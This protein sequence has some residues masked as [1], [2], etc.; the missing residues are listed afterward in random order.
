MAT[1]IRPDGGRLDRAPGGGELVYLDHAASTPCDPRVV[2]AMLPW[3][4]DQAA[5]AGQSIHARGRAAAAAVE[6]A[7]CH[8]LRALSLRRGHARVVLTSGAT[9]ANNLVLL[10]LGRAAPLP[11]RFVV[12][13]TEHASVL[14]AAGALRE[15]GHDVR[16]VPVDRDG[17]LRL[18][19]LEH[20]LEDGAALVS[21]QAVNNETGVVQPTAAIAERAHR[22]GAR[23][24]V[25]AAQAFGKLPLAPSRDGIDFLTLSG[26]KASGPPGTGALVLVGDAAR[27]RLE[28]LVHGGGQEGGLR[29]GTVSVPGA[30][31]LGAAA[32][33]VA[34]EVEARV[35]H[36]RT[37]QRR[38]EFGLLDALPDAS[39]HG[40]GAPRSPYIT[41]VTVPGLDARGTLERME[42][43]AA[44][45]ASACCGAAPSHVLRAMGCSTS[46]A[47][48]TIRLGL[49][50]ATTEGEIDAAIGLLADAA[51]RS[52]L[53]S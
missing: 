19:E 2:E 32:A 4:L 45:T 47:A 22:V 36:A 43:L 23:L 25:D 8:V 29:S 3:L 50:V 21:V 40:A 11:S 39:F 18:D 38:L 12:G 27:A 31:G 48:S 26:H 53:A 34:E 6:Q 15:A 9:E 44:S 13:A 20:A 42:H 28:P 49:G 52:L 16:I 30:V 7:R 5:N 46:A 33:I 41:S 51:G 1:T 17:V 37:L 10:G 24:H 14:A 35:A